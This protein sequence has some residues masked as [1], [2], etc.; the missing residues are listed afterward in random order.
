[1]CNV[2]KLLSK[3]GSIFWVN[4][5]N[6]QARCG[7]DEDPCKLNILIQRGEYGYAPY[8]LQNIQHDIEVV[9]KDIIKEKLGLLFGLKNEETMVDTFDTLKQT[10][11]DLNHYMNLI[12]KDM[13]KGQIVEVGGERG[14]DDSP[15][16]PPARISKQELATINQIRL[17]NL[18]AQFQELIQ[19]FS[20][21][22]VES[23][24]NAKLHD[25][26]ELY[27]EEIIPVLDIL[28]TALYDINT[29]VV[30]DRQYRLIQIKIKMEN[31]IM[32]LEAPRIVSNI[33]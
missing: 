26:I 9:K 16:T 3:V 2:S 22:E 18:I 12:E 27:L 30:Q 29:V 19:E 11:K 7:D 17:G 23:S 33:K 4:G 25:A 14:G 24:R 10:Y 6:L 5:R 31:L 13:L 21:D 20:S 28:R 32:E 15:N 1:M 8:L